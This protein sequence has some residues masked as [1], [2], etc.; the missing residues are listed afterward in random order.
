M[1]LTRP[2]TNEEIKIYEEVEKVI[3]TMN[4]EE[5]AHFIDVVSR[6]FF[7]YTNDKKI[8]NKAYRIVKKYGLNLKDVETWYCIDE[9]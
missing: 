2:A 1:L 7:D 8:Y 4:H 6:R 3:K 5:F 9:Y